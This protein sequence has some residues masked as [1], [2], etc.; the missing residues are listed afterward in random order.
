MKKILAVTIFFLI[1][2]IN[3]NYLS[4][5]NLVC[6]DEKNNKTISVFY[7]FDKIEV[8]DKV[9][10]EIFVFGNGMSGEYYKYKSLFLG[11]GKTLDEKWEI[12]IEL[13]NPKTVS[14][15]KFKYYADEPK[16][17]SD[18]SFLCR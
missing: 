13:R 2:F 8:E 15:S 12:D 4:A 14:L 3:Y 18:N 9:F 16:K 10:S 17:I 6:K 1:L 5:E 11:F 7:T